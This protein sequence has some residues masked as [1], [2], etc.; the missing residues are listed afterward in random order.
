MSNIELRHSFPYLLPSRRLK[1][2]VP[3]VILALLATP[4]LAAEQKQGNVLTLGGG[5]DV[6]PRYSGS[7][8]SR[9]S[10]SQVVD[11]SMANGFFISTTRGIGY[12]NNIGN[13]DYNAAVSYRTGRKD[14]DVSSDSI[15]S[16]SDYLRGMGDIKGSAIVVPGLGYKVTD[17]LNLQLQAEIPVSE[18]DNGE[19]VHFGISSPLYT[20]SKNAVTLGLTGSWGSGKYMQTYYG[21]NAA[22]S[23]ASGFA[24]HDAGAGIYAWSMNLDWTYRLTSRWSVL[25]SAG[26]TQLTG[27][28]GDSPIVQRKTSPTGSLKVTYSF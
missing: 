15:S 3:G 23:A 24:R 26:V 22:Q 27:D 13:L 1:N 6:A 10:A 14:K 17:W 20:S 19:A 2:I 21:V 11:Y 12:G 8:K 28:A 25:T 16:G 5:V 7:D 18:R 4:V 9:V